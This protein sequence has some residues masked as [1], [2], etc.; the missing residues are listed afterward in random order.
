MVFKGLSQKFVLT[1]GAFTLTESKVKVADNMSL[2]ISFADWF[3][4][5]L[6]EYPIKLEYMVQ[7]PNTFVN[8]NKT[9]FLGAVLQKISKF[10]PEV[11]VKASN[12]TSSLTKESEFKIV[13]SINPLY[14]DSLELAD[15]YSVTF[16]T[17]I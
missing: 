13:Y 10:V 6:E 12:Y 16:I 17:L 8:R 7:K 9:Q 11:K 14:G 15:I 4:T 3:R 5:Y 1:N 2:F